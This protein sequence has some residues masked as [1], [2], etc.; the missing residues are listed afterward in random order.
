MRR[1]RGVA[2]IVALVIL[3]PLTLIAVVMMQSSGV[4]LKMAGAAASLQQA[5]HRIEG[6]IES[7][8]L[9]AGL[10]SKIATMGASS[11]LSVNG[12]TV[13]MERRGEGESVCKRK[14][15]ASS[16]NVIPSCRYVELQAAATY[17]KNSRAMN[18]TAGV[19]QP[20]LKAE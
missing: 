6:M 10:S 14:V 17:G 15:D 18:W 19:E 8:L 9:Q 12:N 7:A 11:A 20:L 5:E 4:D 16:Q 2:L 3:V 1:A 13:N